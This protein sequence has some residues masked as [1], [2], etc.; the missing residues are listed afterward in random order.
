[1]EFAFKLAVDISQSK[2]RSGEAI[3]H[4]YKLIQYKLQLHAM[5]SV[6]LYHSSP[7]NVQWTNQYKKT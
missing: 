3:Y 4:I 2:E 6:V 1:M 5:I 7:D